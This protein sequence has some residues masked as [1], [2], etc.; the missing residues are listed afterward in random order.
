M[1]CYYIHWHFTLLTF[2]R[3]LS[4]GNTLCCKAGGCWPQCRHSPIYILVILQHSITSLQLFPG[5]PTALLPDAAQGPPGPGKG[6][7]S[8][9]KQAEQPRVLT[10]RDCGCGVQYRPENWSKLV[11]DQKVVAQGIYHKCLNWKEGLDPLHWVVL[12]TT[13]E[14]VERACWGKEV[15]YGSQC[16]V[17]FQKLFKN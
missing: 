8:P 16:L 10:R 6:P 4:F 9:R 15:K 7:G 11:V 14:R 17:S 2:S 5:F 13:W 3:C 1:S 12:T